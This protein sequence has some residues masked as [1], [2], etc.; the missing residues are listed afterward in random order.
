MK[1]VI[2]AE[3]ELTK[4]LNLTLMT[5]MLNEVHSLQSSDEHLLVLKHLKLQCDKLIKELSSD[6]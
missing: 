6:K 1:N 2:D 3:K 5:E 4:L